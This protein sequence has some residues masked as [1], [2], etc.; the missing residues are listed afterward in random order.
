[1]KGPQEY[2]CLFGEITVTRSVYQA[3]GDRTVCPLEVNA[4]ILHHH[5][6]P[7]A[8]EFV[9]Y[10]TAHMV[11]GELAE[12]CRRWQ[13]LTPSETVLK[14]AAGEI[15]EMAEMLQ[16]VHEEA[17]RRRGCTSLVAMAGTIGPPRLR[18]PGRLPQL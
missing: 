11:P 1:L 6:T 17:A 3:N 2:Q 8:D 5:M 4:G 10:S 13:Y 15:G 18:A 9:A 14:Q 16:D 12:F 7:A